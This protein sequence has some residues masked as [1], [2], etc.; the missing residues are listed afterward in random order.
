MALSC[1]D[2]L[3]NRLQSFDLSDDDWREHGAKNRRFHHLRMDCCSAGV[4]LKQ[5]SRGTRFFAH[6]SAG[7]CTS[8]EE[9]EEHRH[10][11]LMAVEMARAT[12]WQAETEVAGTT[13]TR[14]SWRADVLATKDGAKVA[15]EIQWSG[16]TSDET[17]RR[18]EQYRQSGVR[19]LWLLRQPGFPVQHEL[20]AA[21]IG[22]TLLDG[23]QALVPAHDRMKARHRS[24]PDSW[25]QALPMSD[26]LR[27][28]F[29]GRLK[30][31]TLLETVGPDGTI[32]I[33]GAMADCWDK[34]CNYKT[35]IITSV[36]IVADRGTFDFG[37][38]DLTD[39][40]QVLAEIIQRLPS[41][42]E[43]RVVQKRYSQTQRR[44]YVSNGCAKC[45]R[46]FG[47]F[48]LAHDPNEVSRIAAFPIRV[49]APW[50]RL[51]EAHPDIEID[52]PAWWVRT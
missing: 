28:A 26:F 9:R 14:E 51:L 24:Q 30:F 34:R 37:L 15:I 40:P 41:S 19:G 33:E 43:R 22:G 38:P 23:F 16:Q 10:L 44:S 46:L 50:L 12:G 45:N 32:V 3:G 1:V 49:D 5:S 6:R 13:P 27:A 17:M 8:A 39:H 25:R 29:E 35:Q 2:G 18:Q 7:R 11:K 31:L 52:T 4:V 36:K 20:P 48:M 42:F 47:E 21:C